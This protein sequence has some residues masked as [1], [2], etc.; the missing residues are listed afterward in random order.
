MEAAQ[1]TRRDDGTAAAF[2]ALAKQL[3]L[4]DKQITSLTNQLELKDKQIELKDSQIK[5]QSASLTSLTASVHDLT[6]DKQE[7]RRTI[8]QL[9]KALVEAEARLATGTAKC[10]SD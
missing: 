3:E 10:C 9:Q 4:K 6:G 7:D 8:I 5:D 1:R 2:K